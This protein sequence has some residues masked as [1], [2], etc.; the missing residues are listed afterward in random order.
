MNTKQPLRLAYVYDHRY[1]KCADRIYSEGALTAQTW[2]RFLKGF[3]KVTVFGSIYEEQE[4]VGNLNRVDCEHVSFHSVPYING[5]VDYLKN[6]VIP[7]AIFE[8]EL[9]RFDAVV[10]RVPGELSNNAYWIAKKY[11]IPVGVEVVG[12]P[13]DSYW[14]HGSIQGKALALLARLR[15]KRITQNATHTVYVTRHFLQSR[16]PSRGIT[17]NASNVDITIP[18]VNKYLRRFDTMLPEKR[19]IV[20][21]S[22]SAKVRYKGHEELLRAL[23][24]VRDQL[25]DFRIEMIGP[26]DSTWIKK[27]AIRLGLQDCLV[28]RGKLLAGGE[29]VNWLDSLDIYVHPSKQEGL[30]R[31][32]IEA[33]SRGLPVL[34]SRIAGI[35]ELISSEYLHKPGDFRGLAEQLTRVLSNL[36]QRESM[37]KD[38]Y[39]EAKNY[40]Q[41]IIEQRR[42]SFWLAFSEDVRTGK[43]N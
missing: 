2:N 37:S 23:A 9:S 16:Y 5:A 6:L 24:R 17:T 31:S 13:W 3:D 12:C 35:P 43:S 34:A 11:K 4:E 22:G 28:L 26:G 14:N 38:N 39:R 32:V 15:M 29:V 41:R 1:F 18:E 40:D 27:L 7:N 30:P 42:K 10:V 33:M 25:P 8:K 36:S 20:G 19:M 21:L